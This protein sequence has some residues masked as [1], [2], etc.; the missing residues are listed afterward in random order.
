MLVYMF[1]MKLIDEFIWMYMC[2]YHVICP[3]SADA[4]VYDAHQVMVGINIEVVGLQKS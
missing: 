2:I 4:I 1:P 3:L